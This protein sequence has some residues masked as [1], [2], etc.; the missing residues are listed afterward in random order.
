MLPNV[1]KSFFCW[2]LRRSFNKRIWSRT[3][4]LLGSNCKAA[5]KSVSA[6]SHLS[7]SAKC[8]K[9][10]IL[11]RSNR[12]TQWLFDSTLLRWF[13]P[14]SIH[15]CKLQSLYYTLSI[16]HTNQ[17]RKKKI[18]SSFNLL[19]SHIAMLRWHEIW[20]KLAACFSSSALVERKKKKNC[21]KPH[22]KEI[23]PILSP[24]KISKSVFISREK[25]KGK[26][27]FFQSLAFQSQNSFHLLANCKIVT[28]QFK[29]FISTIFELLNTKNLKM[30]QKKKKN[31]EKSIPWQSQVCLFL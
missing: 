27:F 19:S 22:W 6:S 17:K 24:R 30:A 26:I 14:A 5:F 13:R 15:C 25:Q 11:F 10:K 18:V 9:K 21:W 2:F 31:F 3:A 16:L 4:V 8:E 7:V 28:S 20:T 29:Q 23:L 1:D 12:S